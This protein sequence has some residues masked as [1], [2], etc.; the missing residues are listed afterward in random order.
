MTNSAIQIGLT[1]MRNAYT[2]M[3]HSSQQV[4]SAGT[5]E[6]GA[7]MPDVMDGLVSLRMNQQLFDA[8]AKVVKTGDE[9]L[10]VLVDERV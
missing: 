10:G 1:G 3:M 2:G 9:V 5:L 6:H 4:V 7:G 8:S